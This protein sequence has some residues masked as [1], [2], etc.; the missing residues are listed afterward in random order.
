MTAAAPRSP[1]EGSG[2][3]PVEAFLRAHPGA[4]K[5]IAVGVSIGAGLG[6]GVG[7]GLPGRGAS[8]RAAVALLMVLGFALIGGLIATGIALPSSGRASHARLDPRRIEAKVKEG[9]SPATPRRVATD[10]KE[11]SG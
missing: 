10:R 7:L 2:P 9:V 8:Y 3:T 5:T 4:I 11:S 1:Q 6:L